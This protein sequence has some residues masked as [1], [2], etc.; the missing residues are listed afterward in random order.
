MSWLWLLFFGL[1]NSIASC[2]ETVATPSCRR[3]A[4]AKQNDTCSSIAARYEMAASDFVEANPSLTNCRLTAGTTYCLLIDAS[5]TVSGAITEGGC[6]PPEPTN[7]P[8]ADGTCGGKYT[9]AGSRFGD[10]CS[11]NGYCG[12]STDY[13]GV[14]CNQLYGSCGSE[15]AAGP[16]QEPPQPPP[17][18]T[19]TVTK[20][21]TKTSVVISIS[22]TTSVSTRTMTSVQTKTTTSVSYSYDGSTPVPLAPGTAKSCTF[23]TLDEVTRA[24]PILTDTDLR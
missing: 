3:S 17:A 1:Y 24:S 5:S 15:S 18:V 2:S 20:S 21:T 11:H 6:P 10:C 8:S 16:E 9:C 4:V 7:I 12:S 13:C 14:G 19:I 23:Q 22:T